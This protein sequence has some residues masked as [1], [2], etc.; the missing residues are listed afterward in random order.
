MYSYISKLLNGFDSEIY[1]IRKIINNLNNNE[2]YSKIPLNDLKVIKDCDN[3]FRLRLRNNPN[4]LKKAFWE[5]HFEWKSLE[6]YPEIRGK[7]LDF[8]CGSGHSDIFLAR[9]GFSVHGIDLS[10]IGIAICNYLRKKEKKE[11]QDRLSFQLANIVTTSPN[12]RL[13]D[14]AWASHVFE[15]INNPKPIFN[16][17]AHWLKPNAFLLISVPLGYAYDDTSHV[18]HFFDEKDLRQQLQRYIHVLRVDVIES[19]QVMRALCTYM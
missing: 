13:F 4:A 9:N 16:A 11:V 17:L 2:V 6:C 18:H 5:D 14:A 8:G 15:H 12:D 19:E 3:I 1:A 10:P 7:I